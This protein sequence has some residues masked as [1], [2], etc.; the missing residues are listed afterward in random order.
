[1]RLFASLDN[2]DL[3]SVADQAR[4]AEERGFD[5]IISHENQRDPFIPLALAV[6]TTTSLRL[7]TGVAIAFPRS[8][9]VVANVA[10]DLQ[11]VSNGR[12]ELGLGPQIRP[13]NERR[14][15]TPWSAPAPRLREYI[16]ALQAIFRCW[17]DGEPL[18]FQG[19]HYT[20]T[21]MTPNF[22]PPPLDSPPPP[23]SLAAVGPAM[24]RLAGEVADG[25]Q[26]HGFCTRDYLTEQ[27]TPL[28]AAGRER[29]G[30]G[31]EELEVSCGVFMCTGNDDESVA[32][33]MDAARIRIGFYGSTR[34]YWP[35]FEQHGL[36]DLGQKLLDL[37]KAGRWDEMAACVDD[38]IVRLFAV[39]GTHDELAN[40]V[41]ERFGGLVDTLALAQLPGVDIDLPPDVVASIRQ[42]P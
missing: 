40:V 25:V 17:S 30:R 35:V 38:D 19:E 1:M 9:M 37:S 27:V 36:E 3:R 5:G 12:F 8:P 33:A 20:F 26:L 4:I 11:A 14:F 10:W 31:E 23:I 2:D 28:L 18:D 6:P 34:A 42:I 15:S 13:H 16:Q 41:T 32:T 39:V 7:R 29:S 24:L 22:V 21:L